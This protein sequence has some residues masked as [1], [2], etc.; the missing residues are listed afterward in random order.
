MRRDDRGM[1][2]PLLSGLLLEGF[3]DLQSVADDQFVPPWRETKVSR[4]VQKSRRV[5]KVDWECT[6]REGVVFS[7]RYPRGSR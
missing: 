3:E 5:V 2:A 4:W 1:R 7:G 6:C